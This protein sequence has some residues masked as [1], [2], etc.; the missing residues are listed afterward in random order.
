MWRFNF[1]T[2]VLR[3]I[4]I[5]SNGPKVTDPQIHSWSVE[6]F[7]KTRVGFLGDHHSLQI[8]YHYLDEND[9]KEREE[10]DRFFV[11]SLPTSMPSFTNYLKETHTFT[12]EIAI[13]RHLMPV[14]LGLSNR[15]FAPR[16]Y[17]LQDEDGLLV[18]EGLSVQ[19]FR[20]K[21]GTFDLAHLEQ[22]LQTLASL[23]AA[24]IRLEQR[25]GRTVAKQYPDVIAENA[26]LNREGYPRVAEL[27][28]NILC[29]LAYARELYGDER[30]RCQRLLERLP[31]VMRQMYDLVQP[32]KTYRN[33]FSHADLW[34][35]NI[36]FRYLPHEDDTGGVSK[37][38]APGSEA[39]GARS[40]DLQPVDCVLVDF[41]L[42]RFVPPAYDFNML[43]TLTTAG[44]R[45][46]LRKHWH[47]LQQT[48]YKSL[49]SQLNQQDTSDNFACS[50][51]EHIPSYDE[52][53]ASSE[54]YRKAGALDSFIINYMVLLPAGCLDETFASPDLYDAFRGETKCATMLQLLRSHTKYR[55]TMKDIVD[56]IIETFQI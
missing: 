24:S 35:N 55:E 22:A 36:L 38:R 1:T 50:S 39:A 28:D 10:K 9:G 8:I 20:I 29:L 18:M 15:R 26:W 23:H 47:H 27:E 45:N 3:Q 53:K 44:H 30:E 14:L 32:S 2:Q 31:G 43:V 56:N 42:S 34:S 17:Y 51:I 48:Y 49:Q 11:K 25:L 12:K 46:F 52:F 21:S 4:V 6:P 33:V 7:S 40:R 5:D 54:H 37:G 19:N 16:C 13:Y 41:Q